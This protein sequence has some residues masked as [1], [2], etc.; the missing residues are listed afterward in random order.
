M[1]TTG[2]IV[3]ILAVVV[4]AAIG[5]YVLQQQRSRRL[6]SRFGPE[7]EVAVR[8]F[9]SR[10]KAEDALAAR[11]K[12]ME[13][14][15]VHPLSHEDHVRFADQWRTVQSHFVDDP[16]QSIEEA[17][18]LVSEVMRARGY[19][20]SEFEHRTEDLSVDHPHVVRNYRAAHDIAM[21]HQQ[22]K[23]GTEDLRQGLVHYRDLFD[24]LL[25]ARMVGQREERR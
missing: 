6:R 20:V 9:G 7:Y 3:P 17:D 13:K 16:G 1:T 24:E 8:E 11:E 15:H 2:I 14:I 5:W 22:G 4:I 19:P 10:P 23:A 25:E 18:R 12:R 21:A